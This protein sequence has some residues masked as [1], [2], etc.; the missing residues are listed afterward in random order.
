MPKS[1]FHPKAY[2]LETRN[3]RQGLNSRSKILMILE[4][5]KATAKTLSEQ[6]ELNYRVVFHHL[7]LLEAEKIVERSTRDRKPYTWH[8]TGIGQQK[9]ETI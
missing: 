4:Q 6:T 8:L 9:L 5:K 7:W 3:V 1:A 2:L